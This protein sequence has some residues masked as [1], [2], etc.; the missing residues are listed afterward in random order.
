MGWA[1]TN[2][3]VVENDEYFDAV[4]YGD[5]AHRVGKFIKTFENLDIAVVAI[6]MGGGRSLRINFEMPKIG[7]DV[8]AIGAPLAQEWEGTVTKGVVSSI[9]YQDGS[10][11]IQSDVTIHPGNSGGPLL[12][13]FGNVIGVAVSVIQHEGQG[14]NINFFIPIKDALSGVRTRQALLYEIL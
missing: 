14:T 12:D 9:R 2:F 10:P 7:D 1:L 4:M 11:F 5:E 13:K 8:Y 3:H 6:D